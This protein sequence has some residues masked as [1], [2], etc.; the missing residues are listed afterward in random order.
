MRIVLPAP[1]LQ[2]FDRLGGVAITGNVQAMANNHYMMYGACAMLLQQLCSSSHYRLVLITCLFCRFFGIGAM[3]SVSGA[4]N[5][6]NSAADLIRTIV[7]DESARRI[8]R[9]ATVKPAGVARK[10]FAVP[11][12]VSYSAPTDRIATAFSPDAIALTAAHA[13]QVHADLRQKHG[14]LSKRVTAPSATESRVLLE[15]MAFDLAT[16]KA[17]GLS[18]SSTS[19][20][21]RHADLVVDTQAAT[22]AVDGGA[23]GAGP[24]MQPTTTTTTREYLMITRSPPPVTRIV[25]ATQVIRQKD[26]QQHLIASESN[27][28]T[29]KSTPTLTSWQSASAND[30]NDTA[31]QAARVSTNQTE[32]TV[33]NS[34][35]QMTIGRYQQEVSSR[36]THGALTAAGIYNSNSTSLLFKFTHTDLFKVMLQLQFDCIAYN[37]HVL[38]AVCVNY[39]II[40]TLASCCYM[41]DI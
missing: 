23:T 30:A 26:R 6:P 32:Q 34:N 29:S 1:F 24:D 39:L 7:H 15:T 36:I 40:R 20:L 16:A 8:S 35:Y 28:L 31:T 12:R 25:H 5:L 38:I 17:N 14:T 19:T 21:N 4:D 33:N 18:S 3:Y 10:D 2:C 37:Q 41:T 11:D 27:L 13:R 22:A 9:A